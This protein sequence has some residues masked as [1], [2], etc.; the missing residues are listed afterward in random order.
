MLIA[1]KTTKFRHDVSYCSNM[2]KEA[3]YVSNKDQLEIQKP[4][5]QKCVS[6]YV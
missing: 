6:S 5:Q 2:W 4:L 1:D 3:V